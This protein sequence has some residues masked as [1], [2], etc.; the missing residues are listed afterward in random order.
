MQGWGWE[1]KKPPGVQSGEECEGQQEGLLQ[2]F[3]QQKKDKGKCGPAV[4]NMVTRD[5]EDAKVLN[6]LFTS[7]FTGKT[8]IPG[9]WGE[10]SSKEVLGSVEEDQVREY[11][12]K[13]K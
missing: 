7:A 3:Q 8:G 13:L 2:I 1:S 5:M 10:I 11:L 12:N 6:A 4:G 9:P